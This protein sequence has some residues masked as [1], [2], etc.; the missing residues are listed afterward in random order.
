MTSQTT[1]RRLA[2]GLAVLLASPLGY[3]SDTL[4]GFGPASSEEQLE[5]EARFKAKLNPAD[6]DQWMQVLTE[7]P[8]HVGSAAGAEYAQWIKAQFDSWGYDTEI[9]RYDVSI[10]FPDVTFRRAD[11]PG[12]VHREP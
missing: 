11:R 1:P 2:L 9:A 4:L 12:T 7:Q 6:Q 3:G 5:L 10:P 8:H